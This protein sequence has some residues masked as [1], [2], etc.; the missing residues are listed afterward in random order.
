M[1]SDAAKILQWCAFT[2]FL[3]VSFTT[4]TLL[5]VL[6]I[7]RIY[8]VWTTL[9]ALFLNLFFFVV[10]VFGSCDCCIDDNVITPAEYEMIN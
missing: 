1:R 5:Y 4:C 10:I 8:Q 9:A 6:D 3:A 7:E 2:F